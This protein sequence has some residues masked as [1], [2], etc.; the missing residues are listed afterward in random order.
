MG[1]FY[2]MESQETPTTEKCDEQES[3]E[4]DL[5]TSYINQLSVN[6]MRTRIFKKNQME[7]TRVNHVWTE[8]DMKK[9]VLLRYGSL[10]TNSTPKHTFRELAEITKKSVT[11]C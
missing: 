3:A 8:E 1:K 5:A 4:D 7:C 10:D 6:G 11:W 9:I 2:S